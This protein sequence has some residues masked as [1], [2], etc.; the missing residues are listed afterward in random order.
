MI[1][2]LNGKGGYMIQNGKGGYMT[3]Y[4]VDRHYSEDEMTQDIVDELS[5]NYY[6]RSLN[7]ILNARWVEMSSIQDKSYETLVFFNDRQKT[8]YRVSQMEDA[9]ISYKAK[10][11]DQKINNILK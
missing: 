4:V 1:Y 3:D 9:V 10:Y 6:N 5:K 7:D 11:R 8:G 2:V